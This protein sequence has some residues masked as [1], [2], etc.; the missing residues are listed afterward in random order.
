MLIDTLR[1]LLGVSRCQTLVTRVM[2]HIISLLKRGMLRV[3]LQASHLDPQLMEGSSLLHLHLFMVIFTSFLSYADSAS[4]S[5][6][7]S[8]L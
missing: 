1:Y 4:G 5:G 3:C 6:I 2:T 7:S 8:W